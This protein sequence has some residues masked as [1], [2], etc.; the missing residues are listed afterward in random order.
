MDLKGTTVGFRAD[1][2]GT[3]EPP[4]GTV[5]FGKGPART[6]HQTGSPSERVG[7]GDETKGPARTP[8][9]GTTL[10]LTFLYWDLPIATFPNCFHHHTFV[11]GLR[12]DIYSVN[13]HCN[14]LP[15]QHLAK[16]CY[17]TINYQTM[18]IMPNKMH[19]WCLF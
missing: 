4:K 15:R 6:L 12:R 13:L 19:F 1:P 5:S 18:L 11:M 14:L 2:K 9:N 16:E 17:N 10:G 7:S 8:G 3:L